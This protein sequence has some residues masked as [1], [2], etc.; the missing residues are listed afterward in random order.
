MRW[1]MSRNCGKSTS[2][3]DARRRWKASK[4]DWSESL[5]PNNWLS[6][7]FHIHQGDEIKIG[8]NS[9]KWEIYVEYRKIVSQFLIDQTRFEIPL[10]PR[11]SSFKFLRWAR[12]GKL[13]EHYVGLA[14]H[15]LSFLSECRWW[16][17][18]NHNHWSLHFNSAFSLVKWELT[19][20]K[21][22][23]FFYR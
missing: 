8:K 7:V 10:D 9:D 15:L 12:G 1:C 6:R 3:V 14:K 4:L 20:Q 2:V 5:I 13:E 23:S 16:A 11:F 21:L 17:F 18:W 22:S 19:S